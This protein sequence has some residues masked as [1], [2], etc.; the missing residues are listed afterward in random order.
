MHALI[1]PRVGV[2]SQKPEI[3][4]LERG[5]LPSFA[6]SCILKALTIIHKSARQ[7]P[8]MRRVLSLDQYNAVLKFNNYIDRGKWISITLDLRPTFW[9]GQGIKWHG[10][11]R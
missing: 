6:D 2:T 7:G 8:P 11:L 1:P 4:Y 9:T 10:L 3:A 5:F